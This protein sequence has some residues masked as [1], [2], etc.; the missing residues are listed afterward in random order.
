MVCPGADETVKPIDVAVAV[1]T[2]VEKTARVVRNARNAVAKG[3]Y[4]S[5]EMWWSTRA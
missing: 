3:T 1:C 2:I 5:S 4:S